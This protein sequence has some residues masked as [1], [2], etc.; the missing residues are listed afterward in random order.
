M[1]R[2]EPCERDRSAPLLT[3]TELAAVMPRLALP[4]AQA[5]LEPLCSAMREAD[6]TTPARVA[7]FLA[8]LAHESGQFRYFEELADGSAYEP[9]ST[10]PRAQRRAANLGNTQP[11]DGPRFKGRG[12]I[13]LTGRANYAAASEDLGVDLV[14]SP[15]L[16]ASPAIGFRI[17]AWFWRSRGLNALADKGD[18]RGITRRIN[19]GLNGIEDRERYWAAAKAVLGA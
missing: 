3:L 12:P 4:R 14:R 11:G 16:A 6:I 19:G 2:P 13:Q 18:F 5:F 8:Q 7:A 1:P 9:T 15:M 10:D 17:A